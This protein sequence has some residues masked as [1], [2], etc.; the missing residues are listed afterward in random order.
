MRASKP[1]GAGAPAFPEMKPGLR[2]VPSPDERPRLVRVGGAVRNLE[3]LFH[4]RR[5]DR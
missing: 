4:G 3:G 1:R 5:A 2:L